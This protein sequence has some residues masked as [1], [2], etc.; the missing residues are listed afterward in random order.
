M[1]KKDSQIQGLEIVIKNMQ[2]AEKT[3]TQ[4]LELL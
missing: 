4:K 1:Q 3:L 2:L